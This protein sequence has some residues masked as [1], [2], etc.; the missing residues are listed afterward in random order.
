MS[1]SGTRLLPRNRAASPD[2]LPKIRDHRC[3]P[4]ARLEGRAGP[5]LARWRAAHTYRESGRNV[6]R[7]Q[8]RLRIGIYLQNQKKCPVWV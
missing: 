1:T 6:L 8:V 5:T 4:V 3:V 7:R 2:L